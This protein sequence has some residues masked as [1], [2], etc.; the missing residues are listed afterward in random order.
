M[1][2]MLASINRPASVPDVGAPAI[3]DYR[4]GL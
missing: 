3:W 1:N 4:P 2:E